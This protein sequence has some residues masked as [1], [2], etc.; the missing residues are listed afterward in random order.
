MIDKRTAWGEVSTGALKN[1]IA[2]IRSVLRPGTKVCAV[3]KGDA[4]GLGLTGVK[5]FLAEN[6]LVEMVACGT[7][8]E[9][10][11]LY[12][13][14]GNDIDVLLI[15]FSFA[16]ELYE[17]FKSGLISPDTAIFS[18]WNMSQLSE[19]SELGRKL[20]RK[21]R[22]HIRI[23]EWNSGIGLGHKEFLAHEDE[24][25]ADPNLDVCGLF[26]HIYSSYDEN[27]EETERELKVFDGLVNKIKP[28]NRARLT[29]HV[30]N[31]SLIFN[32]PEY[33]YD[34]AR[35][36]SALLGLP[37]GDGGR[38]RN[39]LS[40]CGTIF[41]IR[42]VDNNVPL[43]YEAAKVVDGTRRIA[44]IMI[45]YADCPL[46]LSFGKVSVMI[47]DRSFSVAEEACMDNLCVD[48][49][50]NDD[51]SVG[52]KAIVLGRPGFD[53]MDLAH[54]YGIKDVH[55]DWMC[56]TSSRLEKVLVE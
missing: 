19:F 6:R 40:I 49:T 3:L 17:D 48:I 37:S 53:A 24:I 52:D 1:N 33:S 18:I 35:S 16:H 2:V 15:G 39:V 5:K 8:N 54:R 43:S 22:A 14:T 45:G 10:R 36:G 42:D 23:D 13:K 4:Y 29:V 21:I 32:H 28:E 34:M 56:I 12:D 31:S 46:L 9:M 50:G 41:S 38:I 27:K 30:Q 20:G 47:K 11:R 55:G 44:R 51:I 7:V 26:G 25:F